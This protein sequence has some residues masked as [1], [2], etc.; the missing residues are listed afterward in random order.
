[1]LEARSAYGYFGT[2]GGATGETPPKEVGVIHRRMPY[3][4]YKRR[5]PECDNMGDYDKVTKTITVCIPCEY[6]ERPNFG[7]RYSMHL[8]RFTY[9]PVFPGCS[10]VFECNAKCYANALK[11]AKQ[12]ARS[13]GRIIIGDAPGYERQQQY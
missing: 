12:W 9:S 1:M 13:V 2:A 10:D 3:W 8:F 4:E 5:Y 7:N 11:N 6:S